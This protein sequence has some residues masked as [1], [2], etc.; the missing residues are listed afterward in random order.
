MRNVVAI[1]TL[2]CGLPSALAGC[3]GTESPARTPIAPSAGP[4]AAA[5]PHIATITPTAVSTTGGAWGKI[6]GTGFRSTVQLTFG[7][8]APQ[9]IWLSD[10]NTIQFWTNAHESGTVD[11][12]V[13]NPGGGQDT[14][15]Q[16]FTFATP[17][18]FDFN[19]SWTG[20]AGD[21]Y[22]TEMSF[23]IENNALTRASCGASQW[24]FATRVPV[25]RGEFNFT[26]EDGLSI[27]GQIMSATNAI[28]NISIAPCAPYW[29][30][31]KE[32]SMRQNAHR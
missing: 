15:R 20:Y 9:H 14:L 4:S 23:V 30:A 18:S 31:D 22:N 32:G 8:A 16:G 28:G 5:D 6:T 27:S 12:V 11:V 1:M 10:P 19:G 29:W 13:R 26:R 24:T 17:E 7:G 25:V 2:L 21:D 3:G